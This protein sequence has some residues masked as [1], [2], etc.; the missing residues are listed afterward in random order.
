MQHPELLESDRSVV[1]V[2]DL[3]GKLVEMCWRS[4]MVLAASRRLMQLAEIFGRSVVLTEQYP[5]G[6]GATHPEVRAVYDSLTVPRRHLRK[7]SFGCCGD[8]AFGRALDELLPA[9]RRSGARSWS[10]GSRRTSA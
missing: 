8:P 9:C 2:I 1:A 10:P 4:A 5:E 6:L 3:Q 7:V